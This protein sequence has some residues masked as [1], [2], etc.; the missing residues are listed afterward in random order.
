MA[1]KPKDILPFECVQLITINQS[2]II[3]TNYILSL[4]KMQQ[5]KVI[6][7]THF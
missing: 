6:N 5:S 2:K 4:G 1:N 7:S 3:T